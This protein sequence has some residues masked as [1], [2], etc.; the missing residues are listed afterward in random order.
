MNAMREVWRIKEKLIKS[1]YPPKIEGFLPCF[2][3]KKMSLF[4]EEPNSKKHSLPFF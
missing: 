3:R 4:F 1:F 2:W